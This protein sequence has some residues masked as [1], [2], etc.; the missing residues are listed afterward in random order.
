MQEAMQA[1]PGGET[2]EVLEGPSGGGPLQ[3]PE[4]PLHMYP[5]VGM[6]AIQRPINNI[7]QE[8]ATMQHLSRHLSLLLS[9]LLL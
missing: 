2:E 8:K 7:S 1:M 6:S 5:S 3:I 9:L 4:E